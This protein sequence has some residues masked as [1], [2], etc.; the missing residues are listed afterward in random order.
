[1]VIHGHAARQ[2]L[3]NCEPIAY[4]QSALLQVH[5]GLG[6][7]RAPMIKLKLS[8]HALRLPADRFVAKKMRGGL[9]DSVHTMLRRPA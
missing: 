6:C 8:R 5:A 3:E 1:M 2:V 4:A 7:D 9:L